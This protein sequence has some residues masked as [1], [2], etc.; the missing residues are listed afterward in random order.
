MLRETTIV[1]AKAA[2]LANSL[3]NLE[4]VLPASSALAKR[5]VDY[6]EKAAE[7]TPAGARCRGC[8]I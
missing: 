6:G 3:G 2:A 1:L 5:Y 4:S 8:W 7:Y